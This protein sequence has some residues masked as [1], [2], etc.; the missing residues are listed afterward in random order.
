MRRIATGYTGQVHGVDS[1]YPDG[2]IKD[3]TGLNDGT[4]F[5]RNNYADIHQFVM[6]LMRVTGITPNNLPDNEYNG[7]QILQAADSR[8]R[9][10]RFNGRTIFDGL[11]SLFAS[12]GPTPPLIEITNQ[13]SGVLTLVGS[14]GQ[15]DLDCIAFRNNDGSSI[16]IVLQGGDTVE[17]A[18]TPFALP[19]GGFVEL[20]LNKSAGNWE[21]VNNP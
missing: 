6:K 5:D 11:N 13:V 10:R 12:A 1:D 3:N 8:F 15:E 2:D 17:G 4:Y 19:A 9:H 21:I 16:N 7:H 18:G 14:S 20:C